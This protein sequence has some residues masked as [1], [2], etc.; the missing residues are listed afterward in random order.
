M[1]RAAL[2]QM[3]NR[4]TEI[5]EFALKMNRLTL[6]L[7]DSIRTL[8]T[9]DSFSEI[10]AWLRRT[11]EGMEIQSARA[12]ELGTALGAV[13]R[14]YRSSEEKILMHLEEGTADRGEERLTFKVLEPP[15]RWAELMRF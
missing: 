7:E 5:L 4:Q 2:N 15:G 13:I 3:E 8:G 12:K 9:M 6:R 14:S 10:I 1:F 11:E